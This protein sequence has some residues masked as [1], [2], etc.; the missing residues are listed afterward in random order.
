MSQKKKAGKI[1]ARRA[2]DRGALYPVAQASEPGE[3]LS[4]D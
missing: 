3:V 2:A 1:L 4:E